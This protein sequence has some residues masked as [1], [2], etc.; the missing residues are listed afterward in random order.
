MENE[1]EERGA[2][3][4]LLDD[5]LLRQWEGVSK[6]EEEITVRSEG[7][8]LQVEKVQSAPRLVKTQA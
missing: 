4:W 3:D 1:L 2:M 7:R 8:R 5:E 6:E